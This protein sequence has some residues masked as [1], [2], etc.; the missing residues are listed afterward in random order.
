MTKL[1]V[2]P[3]LRGEASRKIAALEVGAENVVDLKCLE[4]ARVSPASFSIPAPAS[5]SVSSPACSDFQE[6]KK[7]LAWILHYPEIRRSASL[8]RFLSF[9]CN[10]YFEGEAKDI[11]EYTIAVEALGRKE[12]SFDSHIDP[13]VRVTAR[14]LRKRL[15]EI[16]KSDGQ[17]HSVHIAL[18]LGH[19]VPQF[20]RQQN[21]KVEPAIPAT[22]GTREQRQTSAP[23]VRIS[24]NP[25]VIRK[26]PTWKTVPI[27]LAVY[28]V[29]FA[30]F[31]LGHHSNQ[32]P[33][34]R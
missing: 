27:L 16:Y 15:G 12:S 6:E 26:R 10:K 28:G 34:D 30:G 31:F 14:A 4:L 25:N 7:E 9:V 2:V 33:L 19:Y 32:S 8:V 13:I 20:V 23:A 5:S 18:P 21:P 29:F 3:K 1:S 24:A 22:E 17:N 11:R